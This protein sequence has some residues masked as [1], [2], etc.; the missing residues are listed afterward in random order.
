MHLAAKGG[1]EAI[2]RALVGDVSR[3]DTEKRNLLIAEDG[4]GNTALH[5]DQKSIASFLIQQE[6]ELSYHLNKH[7]ESAIYLAAKAGLVECV[8][9]ILA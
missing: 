7:G 5:Q 9:S 3:N 8:S 6:P 4:M 2:V 1:D